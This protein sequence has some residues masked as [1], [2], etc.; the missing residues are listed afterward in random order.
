M[1]RKLLSDLL[2]G[3]DGEE[4]GFRGL[5]Q[6]TLLRQ[7]GLGVDH[8]APRA[9]QRRPLEGHREPVCSVAVNLLAW[10]ARDLQPVRKEFHHAVEWCILALRVEGLPRFIPDG[11]RLL[12]R[13]DRS[14][15]TQRHVAITL[16]VEVHQGHSRRAI[17]L[18]RFQD[19]LVFPGPLVC[20]DVDHLQI[21]DVCEVLEGSALDDPGID[22]VGRTHGCTAPNGMS[23]HRGIEG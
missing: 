14:R 22:L 17:L 23:G 10:T 20:V 8:D 19:F 6:L 1:V 13:R 15:T 16:G 9:L 3:V 18:L 4:A 21:V 7:A 2:S 12:V 11:L 5:L